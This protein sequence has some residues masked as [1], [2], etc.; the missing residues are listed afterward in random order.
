MV[1]CGMAAAEV[2]VPEVKNI[3]GYN[4]HRPFTLK[5]LASHT[6]GLDRE[7]NALE[8]QVPGL[9]DELVRRDTPG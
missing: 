1:W 7:P 8:P 3:V 9:T 5:M 4:D 2:L 6:S